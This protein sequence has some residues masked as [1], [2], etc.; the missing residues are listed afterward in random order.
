MKIVRK[1]KTFFFIFRRKPAAALELL[2]IKVERKLGI[3]LFF[4][5]LRRSATHICEIIL[6]EKVNKQ[7]E[8][9]GNYYIKPSV[10]PERPIIFSFGVG[11]NMNDVS[12]D[13]AVL[14]KLHPELYLVDPTPMSQRFIETLSLPQNVRFFPIAIST[15][16]GEID[17]YSGD[18]EE[19]FEQT[20]T[21]SIYNNGVHNNNSFRV[22]SKRLKTFMT[23][24]GI[25]KI[26]ILKMDIEGAAISVLE[27]GLN[28]GILPTQIMCEFERPEK[29]LDVIKYLQNVSR[30]FRR[31][32]KLGY[33]IYRTRSSDKGCQIEFSAINERLASPG[34]A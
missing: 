20:S 6:T 2:Q 21:V 7:L 13:L 18:I 27:D 23:D 16:D 30:L 34:V 19:N 17:L 31:L 4:L 5:S 32:R 9:Y 12:F 8:L 25:G 3:S 14:K 26:D 10:L 33:K 24:C 22:K 28:D 15:L 1:L 11:Q 29:L